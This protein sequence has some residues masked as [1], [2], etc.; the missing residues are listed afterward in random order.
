MSEPPIDPPQMSDG[1]YVKWLEKEY[2]RFKAWVNDLQSGMYINCVYCGHRYGPREDTPVAMADVLKAHIEQCPEH[3]LSKARA[4]IADLEAIGRTW[5][6]KCRSLEGEVKRL[7]TLLVDQQAR[8]TEA[9][10]TMLL[11]KNKLQ[12]GMEECN[13]YR[14]VA[15]EWYSEEGPFPE[16]LADQDVIADVDARAAE[17][18]NHESIH[19][20]GRTAE[21]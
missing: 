4:R 2:S 21:A 17:K 3:P 10:R 16:N 6:E 12:L 7:N 14:D 8:W 1:E 18:V 9:E 5:A 15:I 11:M 20:T 19:Q 13:A